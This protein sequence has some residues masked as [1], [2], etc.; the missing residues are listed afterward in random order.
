MQRRVAPHAGTEL[1]FECP[2]TLSQVAEELRLAE[3]ASG[4]LEVFLRESKSEMSR[5]LHVRPP[6][7]RDPPGVVGQRGQLLE[8]PA[9]PEPRPPLGAP[10]ATH[11]ANLERMKSME[12]VGK[13]R[14]ERQA[15][16]ADS[17]AALGAQ[18][19]APG[20]PGADGVRAVES[21][22]GAIVS[23]LRSLRDKHK[24]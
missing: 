9:A 18:A 22:S 10:Q 11:K 21:A 17:L 24:L 7:P 13:K 14:R 20:S 6:R 5:Q 19:A 1:G 3:A 2:P 4:K 16:V 8:T 15:A 12:E 23:G